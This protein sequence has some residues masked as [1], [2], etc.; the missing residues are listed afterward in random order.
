MLAKVLCHSDK[1]ELLD[2]QLRVEHGDVSRSADKVGR[3]AGQRVE[4]TEALERNVRIVEQ[5]SHNVVDHVS[6]GRAVGRVALR[7]LAHLDACRVKG[8]VAVLGRGDEQ[9]VAEVLEGRLLAQL[10]QVGLGHVRVVL[11]RHL[12]QAAGLLP[13]LDHPHADVDEATRV[14]QCAQVGTGQGQ[15]RVEFAHERLEV[16]V[17]H[18]RAYDQVAFFGV[19]NNQEKRVYF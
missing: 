7:R 3:A 17:C 4:G 14:V 11:E 18:S 19:R 15:V 13:L 12:Q 16:V 10:V 9:Y 2:E 1:H 5:R 8:H 6:I